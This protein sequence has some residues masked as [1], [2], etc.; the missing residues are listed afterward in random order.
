MYAYAQLMNFAVQQKQIQHCKSTTPQQKNYK[1][2]KYTVSCSFCS[3]ERP[4]SLLSA[5]PL[6]LSHLRE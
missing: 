1:K 2:N 4:F 5:L 6:F 3:L